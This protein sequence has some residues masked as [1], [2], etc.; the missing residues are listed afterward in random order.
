VSACRTFD[1]SYFCL[2]AVRVVSTDVRV[3]KWA[4]WLRQDTF[5][6]RCRRKSPERD[7]RD[8]STA[9]RSQKWVHRHLQVLPQLPWQWTQH[10]SIANFVHRCTDA[11][12]VPSLLVEYGAEVQARDS[13]GM[14]PLMLA[15]ASNHEETVLSLLSLCQDG[16]GLLL[17][18]NDRRCQPSAANTQFLISCLHRSCLTIAKDACF[19]NILVAMRNVPKAAAKAS[20]AAAF[21]VFT[22]QMAAEMAQKQIPIA[23]Q[24]RCIL[25]CVAVPPDLTCSWQG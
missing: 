3:S 6:E 10:Q 5:E 12:F 9:L 19:S 13:T 21:A 14:T 16:A 24:T 2:N 17:Q 8:H 15:V 20:T 25:L 23:E 22:A 18:D 1:D 7:V 11:A 4:Y